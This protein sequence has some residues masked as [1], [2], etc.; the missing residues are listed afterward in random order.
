MSIGDVNSPERGSGARFNDGKVDLTLLPPHL[1]KEMADHLGTYLRHEVDEVGR[2][3]AGDDIIPALIGALKEDEL[4]GAARVFEYGK[5]KYAAWNWAKGMLWSVPVAC[6]LRH[7]LFANPEEL[8]DESGLPHRHHAV[9]NLIMLDHLVRFCPDMDDRPRELRAEFHNPPEDAS[10]EELGVEPTL[11]D[12]LHEIYIDSLNT[13]WDDLTQDFDQGILMRYMV[14]K[15]GEA[16]KPIEDLPTPALNDLIEAMLEE[17]EARI[18]TL[19]ATGHMM[20]QE[21]V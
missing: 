19:R 14:A 12:V 7:S 11:M 8:D 21:A 4:V 1:W 15:E 9:C 2:F 5:K 17:Q 10:D 13:G 20:S 6:Y 16:F 3:W 18:K